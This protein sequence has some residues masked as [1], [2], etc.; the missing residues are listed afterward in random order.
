MKWLYENFILCGLDEFQKYAPPPP[1]A[2]FENSIHT[3]VVTEKN[4]Y[5]ITC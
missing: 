4:N 5:V 2:V 3:Y 1:F